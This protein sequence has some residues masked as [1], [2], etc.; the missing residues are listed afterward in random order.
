MGFQG[1]R[2]KRS[3]DKAGV[4]NNFE[5][6]VNSTSPDG[7]LSGGSEEGET[8]ERINGPVLG[9]ESRQFLG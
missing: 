4:D 7:S 3:T 8:P 1:V 9:Q 5:E 6:T 2:G